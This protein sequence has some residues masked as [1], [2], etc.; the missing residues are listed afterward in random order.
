MDAQ[1]ATLRRDF[2][3][4]DTIDESATNQASTALD[5]DDLIEHHEAVDR[6]AVPGVTPPEAGAWTERLIEARDAL[7]EGI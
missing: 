6:S 7:E 3:P 2:N 1:E 4:A 5:L